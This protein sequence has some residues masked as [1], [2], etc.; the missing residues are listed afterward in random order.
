MLKKSNLFI[1]VCGIEN[2]CLVFGVTQNQKLLCVY[3]GERLCLLICW[4]VPEVPKSFVLV[5]TFKI[6]ASPIQQNYTLHLR[7]I[8]MIFCG[9]LIFFSNR[10]PSQVMSLMQYIL[11]EPFDSIIS[12]DQP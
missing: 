7:Y 6:F 10:S 4:P 9:L 2:T 5:Q 8:L 11:D 1:L 12:V 3:A